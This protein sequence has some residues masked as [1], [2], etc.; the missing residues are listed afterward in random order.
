MRV[1][2]TLL[3]FFLLPACGPKVQVQVPATPAVALDVSSAAVV[4]RDRECRP[5]A[6]AMIA[7]LKN[8]AHIAVDPRAQ[9]KLMVSDCAVDIGWTVHQEVDG[10]AS[11]ERQR[12]DIQGRGHAL[13][14]VETPY[15]TV[16]QVIGSARE[17]HLGSW[18][19]R[20]LHDMLRTRSTVQRRL[21]HS[22]ASDLV[23]QLNNQPHQISRRVYPNADDG[24]AKQL[25]SLAVLAEQR[26]DLSE[27]IALA[28]QAHD[29]EPTERTASYLASLQRRL[30]SQAAP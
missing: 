20:G 13:L 2:S 29:A 3:L 30:Y 7:G 16:A 8:S 24:T 18:R 28:E 14:S 19:S 21:T 25:T 11:S 15:G 6:D 9:I 26:G 10:S 22:V 4:A 17:G 1:V 5:I 23:Q 12:A 27:A